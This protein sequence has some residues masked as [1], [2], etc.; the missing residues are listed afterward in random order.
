MQ[1]QFSPGVTSTGLDPNASYVSAPGSQYL[2]DS[3][4]RVV[5]FHGVN[6]VYKRAPYIAYPDPG[7][8]WNFDSS[9]AKAIAS[10]GFNVVRLGIEW[11]AIEPGSGP[12]NQ[13]KICTPGK[14]QNPD[15][16]N[17]AVA[18]RYLDKVAETV[19]LLSRYGIYTLLDMHQD[20][21]S[22]LFRGEGAPAWA[23]C[24]DGKRIVPL[25][26]RWSDNYSNA[27]LD[28]AEGD[29]WRNDVVGNLQGQYDLSWETVA[30]YFANDPWIL[31][32]DPYNEPFS[33]SITLEQRGQFTTELECFYA[34]T[35][36]SL[37][38]GQPP[39]Q[40]SCPRDDPE[41]GV[42]PTIEGVDPHHLI[43]VEPD[44]FTAR[45]LPSL[46]G[47]MPFPRLVYNFHIYCSE[48]SPVT[49]NPT[50]LEACAQ[51]E[52]STALNEIIARFN[53]ASNA[54]P[55]GPAW[56][57]SEFGATTSTELVGLVTGA[58]ATTNIGWTYWSWKYYKDP[59]G[60]RAEPLV[61]PSGSY[62]PILPALS[63]T[64]AQAVAGMPDSV[65][66]DP[67]SGGF[68]MTYSP[69]VGQSS[70]TSI[71]VAASVHYPNGWC[72]AVQGGTVASQPGN[73]LLQIA[74]AP[75]ASRVAV[76][77]TGGRCPSS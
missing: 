66:V 57:M 18:R 27:T 20:V 50:N 29:F 76:T 2:Y 24:T 62:S 32:Y 56:F 17:A 40:L 4:G 52:V 3:N 51:S 54:Q 42:V 8:P 22:Q 30:K 26:G 31:G 23:V 47:P 73:V 55:G 6:V 71:Y 41:Y 9:D 43:F 49:G 25:G 48:R 5:L 14:P 53:M 12:P 13:P 68:E 34:G 64:Y 37:T 38:T 21:Y 11:Q 7:K 35:G 28:I 67:V 59:T 70:S 1:Y 65:A 75:N 33:P 74:T 77:V 63:F 61:Q 19:N 10:L 60:S 45:G 58:A 44:N 39:T 16:F 15:E 36:A 72:V 46:L 69:G